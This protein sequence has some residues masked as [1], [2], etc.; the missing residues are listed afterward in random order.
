[1]GINKLV[2]VLSFDSDTDEDAVASQI[3][4]ERFAKL[5]IPATFAVPGSQLLSG[6]AEY[7]ALYKSGAKFINHGGGAHTDFRDGR[8]WSVNFYNNQSKESVISD[9]R[10][11]HNIFFDTFGEEARGFRAPHF[12]HFQERHQLETIYQTLRDLGTYDFSTTTTAK[13]A[14]KH[15]PIVEEKGILEIPIVGTYQW[16]TRIFDSWGHIAD[17]RIRRVTDQYAK[18]L[19]NSVLTCAEKNIPAILNYYADPSHV[20]ENDDYFSVLKRLKEAGIQ[21]AD[22]PQVIKGLSISQTSII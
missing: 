14:K 7:K 10:L 12:G 2:V 5:G 3:L 4:Y 16:P 11:G 9:I 21:F 17:K 20:V 18:G 13:T 1:M 19:L 15:G 22:Y 8:Y 6:K